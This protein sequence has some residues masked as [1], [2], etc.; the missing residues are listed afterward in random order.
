[1]RWGGWRAGWSWGRAGF[2]G[3]SVTAKSGPVIVRSMDLSPSSCRSRGGLAPACT[4]S[5]QGRTRTAI[6]MHVTPK[7]A[8][9]HRCWR[10]TSTYQQFVRVHNLA[11]NGNTSRR[12]YILK[13]HPFWE[14]IA[15]SNTLNTPKVT[16]TNCMRPLARWAWGVSKKLDSLCR[17]GRT[18]SW[19]KVKNPNS[20]AAAGG[21]DGTF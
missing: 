5:D 15:A 14:V 20:P 12:F 19:I 8:L 3:G 2:G 1:T 16:A 9:M 7:P 21:E 13:T 4:S 6:E 10:P 17:S 11:H 18:K